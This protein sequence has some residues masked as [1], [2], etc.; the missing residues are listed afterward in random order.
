MKIIMKM[1]NFNLKVM[2]INVRGLNDRKKRR[3]VFRRISEEILMFV[4]YKNP[5]VLKTVSGSGGMNGV[6]TYF[7]HT[8]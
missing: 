3:G 2:S 5:I 8:V 1:A 4:V 7:L 6:E